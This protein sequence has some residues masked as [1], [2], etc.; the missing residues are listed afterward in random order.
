LC[1]PAKLMQPAEQ[2]DELA[3][4]HGRLTPKPGIAVKYNRQ[5]CASQ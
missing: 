3:P 4:P 1:G 2:C 5:T